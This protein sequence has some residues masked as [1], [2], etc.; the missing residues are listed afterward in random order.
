M[1]KE[2]YLKQI[3]AFSQEL[4]A[5]EQKQTL[6]TEAI[7]H[8]TNFYDH[9]GG[10]INAAAKLQS[11][12]DNTNDK[13]KLIVQKAIAAMMKSQDLMYPFAEDKDIQLPLP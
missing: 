1:N 10:A 3:I 13:R 2:E 11:H 8:L 9:I 7:K 4:L 6:N 12:F 5:Q